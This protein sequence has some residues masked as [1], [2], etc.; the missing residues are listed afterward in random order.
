M[1][2]A[3]VRTLE[4]GPLAMQDC[5]SSVHDRYE[6]VANLAEAAAAAADQPLPQVLHVPVPALHRP[7]EHLGL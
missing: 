7:E 1:T 4:C 6:S 2:L 3:L 5:C